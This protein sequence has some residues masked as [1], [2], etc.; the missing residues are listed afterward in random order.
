MEDNKK[1]PVDRFLERSDLSELESSI[2]ARL[3]NGKQQLDET[4]SALQRLREEQLKVE[5]RFVGLSHQVKAMADLATELQV[6]HE[7]KFSQ[8]NEVVSSQATASAG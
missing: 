2:A 5:Q 1:S 4:Q 3:V 6:R 8:T 7:S